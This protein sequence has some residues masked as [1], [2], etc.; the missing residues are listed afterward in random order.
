MGAT[1]APIDDAMRSAINAQLAA[2]TDPAAAR[3][4]CAGMSPEGLRNLAPPVAVLLAAEIARGGDEALAESMLAARLDL[5]LPPDV[6]LA[7]VLTGA[8]PPELRHIDPELRAA[9]AFVRARKLAESGQ[10][11]PELEAQAERDDLLRGV[12]ARARARWPA[13]AP[14]PL[15]AAPSDAPENTLVL[16]RRARP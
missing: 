2:A 13:P 3:S 16:R 5:P 9:L 10:K 7:Y 8:E 15:V 12:V 11:D 1:S 14:A 4:V 6:L